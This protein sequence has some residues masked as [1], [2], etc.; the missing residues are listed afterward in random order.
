[1]NLQQ[2]EPRTAPGRLLEASSTYL[3]ARKSTP[4]A[5]GS[6]RILSPREAT[7][8]CGIVGVTTAGAGAAGAGGAGSA[9]LSAPRAAETK[10][11]SASIVFCSCSASVQVVAVVRAMHNTLVDG[12]G[13]SLR[14]AAHAAWSQCSST[15]PGSPHSASCTSR[16]RMSAFT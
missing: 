12:N 9:D 16:H 13:W 14:H 11:A 6:K 7:E 1:M 5:L 3:A 8:A 2:R 4:P 15:T 10:G